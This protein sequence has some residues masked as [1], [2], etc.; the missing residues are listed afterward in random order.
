MRVYSSLLSYALDIQSCAPWHFI[1]IIQFIATATATAT[2]TLF[3]NLSL[4]A[5]VDLSLEFTPQIT[6]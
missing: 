1:F 5:I 4:N 3:D 6:K 2:A